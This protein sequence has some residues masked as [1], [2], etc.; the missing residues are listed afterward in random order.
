MIFALLA[1]AVLDSQMVLQRYELELSQLK[2][3]Q[4]QIFSYSVSQ[5]G[6]AAIEQRHRIYRSGLNVRDETIAVDGETL[7]PKVV[8]I[9]RRD[10]RYD[11]AKVAPRSA[12]YTM[13]FLRMVRDG[14]HMDYA[15]EA[16]PT[17]AGA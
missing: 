15:F 10:D 6:A 16:T 11:I 17:R 8:K 14:S 2:A 7:K 1:A 3:P 4:A 9:M 13:L 5:E 12:N